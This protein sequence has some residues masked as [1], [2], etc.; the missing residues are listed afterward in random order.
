MLVS[1]VYSV[2]DGSEL[3][4]VFMGSQSAAQGRWAFRQESGHSLGSAL[5]LLIFL[6]CKT[7]ETE[8]LQKRGGL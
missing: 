8:D 3:Q 6:L 7:Q 2:I 5:D 4:H 1:Q